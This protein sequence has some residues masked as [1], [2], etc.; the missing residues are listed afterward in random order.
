V[1]ALKSFRDDLAI[2]DRLAKADPANM[3]WQHDL[4]ASYGRL[5]FLYL[6]MGDLSQSRSAFVQGREIV[7]RLVADHPGFVRWEND[8]VGFDDL[9]A[10]T[11][12]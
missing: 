2:A 5:G 6:Q 3:G 10:A 9:I 7:A 8:L 11:N 12:P 1:E 4:S